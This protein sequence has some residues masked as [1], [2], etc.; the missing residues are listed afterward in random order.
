MCWSR[1]IPA[2]RVTACCLGV[3]LSSGAQ[4]QQ[5]ILVYARECAQ[6]IGPIPAFDCRT[7]TLVPI[8]VN[9]KVPAAYRAQMTCDRPSL[10]PPPSDENTDGQCV[11]NSRALVL[12]DDGKVQISAFCR[13]K[14]IRPADTFLYDEVDIVAHSVETGSTCWFQAQAALPL[15]AGK[16]LDGR[17]VPPPDEATPP[18]GQKAARDFWNPPA[19]TASANCGTCHDSDPFMYSPFIGQTGQMPRDPLGLYANDIGEDFKKWPKPLSLST[20]GNTCTG[21]HRIGSQH[22]CNTAM[23]E[24]IGQT[25]SPGL[26]SWALVFPNSHWMP[27]TTGQSL[28]QWDT[29]YQNSVQELARCCKDPKASGCIATPIPGSRP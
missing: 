12:R 8:T 14:K 10:L 23:Y 29:T 19:K 26:D 13:Q 15:S 2:L 3:L 6:K 7:G 9:G 20:R 16:G 4:A 1:L 28:E 5:D 22:T 11:P 25:L 27:P 17:R 24:S 18:A 21:C